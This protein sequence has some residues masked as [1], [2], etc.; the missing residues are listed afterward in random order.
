[1]TIVLV[2]LIAVSAVMALL[3]RAVNDLA[4]GIG[5]L[6]LGI[7]GVRSVLAPQPLPGVSALDL[8]LSWLILILLL[9]L[10]LRAAHHFHRQSDLPLP[11]P[12]LPRPGR[13][14]RPHQPP[15]SPDAP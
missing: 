15:G 5:G 2:L 6:I 14:H 1:L 11:K 12:P 3:T 9:G 13:P 10:A 4:L 7:W 8:A